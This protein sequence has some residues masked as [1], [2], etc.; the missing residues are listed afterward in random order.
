VIRNA[1]GIYD[2]LLEIKKE[3]HKIQAVKNKRD[4]LFVD[5]WK[6]E[7]C[8]VSGCNLHFLRI[9]HYGK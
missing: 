3:G 6:P 9:A 1:I 8:K 4:L 2:Y 7:I 5:F